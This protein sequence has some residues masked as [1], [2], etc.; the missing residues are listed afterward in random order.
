MLLT[1]MFVGMATAAF[2]FI[3]G[4]H[5]F[6]EDRAQNAR[7]ATVNASCSPTTITWWIENR[8][9][10]AADAVEGRLRVTPSGA[11]APVVQQDFN[12]AINDYGFTAPM[13]RDRVQLNLNAANALNRTPHDLEFHIG[14]K[15]VTARCR[16][17][18]DWFDANWDYRRPILIDTAAAVSWHSVAINTTELIDANKLRPDCHDIR[19]VNDETVINYTFSDA[20]CGGNMSIQFDHDDDAYLYYGN[21]R[22]DDARGGGL[23][24]G[25]P[26]MAELGDEERIT[27]PG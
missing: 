22:A 11:V 12:F 26:D 8:N 2:V 24:P 19:V 17:G 27:L 23:P 5:G 18:E 10:Y 16:P 14:E 13:G 4:E 1:A 3:E 9:D 15:R 21:N 20:D 25:S 6:L 7:F